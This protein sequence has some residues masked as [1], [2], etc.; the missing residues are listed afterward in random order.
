M[1]LHHIK[2]HSWYL[3]N[4][5]LGLTVRCCDW[6][7][8]VSHYTLRCCCSGRKTLKHWFYLLI[9][10]QLQKLIETDCSG[11][12]DWGQGISL[13]QLMWLEHISLKWNYMQ[14]LCECTDAN[15]LAES[16]I[17]ALILMNFCDMLLIHLWH[18]RYTTHINTVRFV[19][20]N[21]HNFS[22]GNSCNTIY[23]KYTHWP[24]H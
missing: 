5:M 11:D 14:Q 10:W 21:T 16:F 23:Q 18:D 3:F 15:V 19:N 24:L 9:H 8:S 12:Y 1:L 13:Y 2:G 17:G 4:L 22:Q 20:A 7:H 6:D